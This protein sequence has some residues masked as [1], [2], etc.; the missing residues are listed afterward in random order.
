MNLAG[1]QVCQ[2]CGTS[3]GH[4]FTLTLDE[5]L[6]TG[7]IVRGMEIDEDAVRAGE[8]MAPKVREM[9]LKSGDAALVRVT[10]LLPEES[11]HRLRTIFED[12]A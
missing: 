6:R 10:Q 9:V 4:S 2:H 3:L 11:W 12:A 8:Q 1:A 7:A 5:A